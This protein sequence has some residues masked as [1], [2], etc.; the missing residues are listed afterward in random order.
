MLLKSLVLALTITVLT[1]SSLDESVDDTSIAEL[2]N[3][4]TQLDADVRASPK[5]AA[6][7]GSQMKEKT[8]TQARDEIRARATDNDMQVK[9][10]ARGKSRAGWHRHR[11]HVHHRHHPHFHHRHRPHWHHRHHRHHKD[12]GLVGFGHLTDSF[13]K[14]WKEKMPDDECSRKSA[15][16]GG[17]LGF[18]QDMIIQQQ[19]PEAAK[20]HRRTLTE[21]GPAPDALANRKLLA[22]D[23]S[24]NRD[25][26]CECVTNDEGKKFCCTRKT[27]TAQFMLWSIKSCTQSVKSAGKCVWYASKYLPK[28]YKV[29]KCFCDKSD[30]SLKNKDI[31]HSVNVVWTVSR[32]AFLTS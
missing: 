21:S 18:E 8:L 9:S 12:L 14:L 13:N 22:K 19:T 27:S 24:S 31:K 7:V 11:W 20:K 15:A 26:H 3:T 10:K 28:V 1:A 29:A 23:I 17:G 16:G 30:K 5:F 32:T 25:K 6:D 2:L 4:D